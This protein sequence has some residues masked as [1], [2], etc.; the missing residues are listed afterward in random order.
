M[1]IVKEDKTRK[2]EE[3]QIF[4]QL[5]KNKVFDAINCD[6]LGYW[7]DKDH[8]EHFI[9]ELSK[10]MT[11]SDLF[12]LLGDRLKIMNKKTP[13]TCPI[14]GG[15]GIVPNGFYSS[16]NETYT[17]ISTAPEKCKSCNGTGIVWNQ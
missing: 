1:L 15:N 7:C 3:G 9:L 12:R 11:D 6:K 17:V 16:L 13:H 4:V 8:L 10:V 14:C 5:I 2:Y